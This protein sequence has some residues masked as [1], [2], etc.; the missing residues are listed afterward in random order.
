MGVEI[1]RKFLLAG[2]SW[3]A[4]ADEGTQIRQGFLSTD[5]ERVVR[6]RVA[7]DRGT[8]TVKGL[9]SGASRPEFE[10][11]IPVEEAHELL[12]TLALRP[13]IEKTRYL[14]RYA[15]HTWEVD[16]FE[17]RNQ[18]LVV[19]EVE[20]PSVDIEVPLP[21]WAGLEVTNDA[22]YANARLVQMPFDAWSRL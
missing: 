5:K 19:A 20:L 9:G 1:E 6:V 17:G 22:R 8:L 2:D 18:G 12:D 13:F 7:G 16:V 21:E 4:S 14:V 10:W 3:R 11:T 15:G